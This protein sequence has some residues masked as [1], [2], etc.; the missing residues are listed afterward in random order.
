MPDCLQKEG[1][2]INIRV[3]KE[4]FLIIGKMAKM[5]FMGA[6]VT[7]AFIRFQYYLYL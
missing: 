1:E 6:Y 7:S 5:A 2:N 3:F 4:G